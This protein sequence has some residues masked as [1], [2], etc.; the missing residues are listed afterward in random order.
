MREPNVRD[1]A[2]LIAALHSG[3]Y[4]T[5]QGPMSFDAKGQPVGGVGVYIEQWQ[6]GQAIF[7]Y[8]SSV[9]TAAPEYPKK[10]WQ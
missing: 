3:T 4:Q 2:K 5:V 9:A 8:P 6:G 7:V 1:Y 10:S